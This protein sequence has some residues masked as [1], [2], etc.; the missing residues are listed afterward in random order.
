MDNQIRGYWLGLKEGHD[1]RA[2]SCTYNVVRKAQ[3]R[4]KSGETQDEF[5]QRIELAYL[6]R[7][8]HYF[9]RQKIIIRRD[10]VEN[11][12]ANLR[13]ANNEYQYI[14]EN[15]DPTIPESWGTNDSHCDSYF[16][17]CEYFELCT[18]GLDY[19]SQG[20]YEQRETAHTE[21]EDV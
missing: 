18:K 19:M 10:E 8:D 4:R 9:H 14:L 20:L 16:K 5:N 6:E 15:Y 2:K 13:I 1:Y 21:L 3:L 17:L 7:P 11:F 12:I